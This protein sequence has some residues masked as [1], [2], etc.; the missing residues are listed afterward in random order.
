MSKTIKMSLYSAALVLFMSLIT[1]CTES[2]EP[3]LVSTQEFV[4]KSLDSLESEGKVGRLGC[5]EF[6]FPITIDFAD[7][8]SATVE[9]YNEGRETIGAWKEA[10]P[11]AEERP[12]LAYPVELTTE[13]GELISVE[14]REE[15]GQL[16]RECR[17]EFRRDRRERIR[18]FFRRACF[19]LAYPISVEFPNGSVLEAANAQTLKVALREWKQANPGAQED[20]PTLIYPITVEYDDGTQTSVNSK[21]ELIALKDTCEA[22]G[23]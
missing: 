20:K 21:E 19:S 13:E 3:T 23:E 6:V 9:S 14:S 15:L 7:G 5:Y 16:R 18:N 11:D 8:T 2:D 1:S 4:V 17:R 12:T 10:N 22:E